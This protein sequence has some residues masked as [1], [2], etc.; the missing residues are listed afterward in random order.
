MK[1]FPDII[2]GSERWE[3]LRRERPTA[4]NFKK[5]ITAKKGEMSATAKPYAAHLA[6]Q[7]YFNS[8]PDADRR[9]AGNKNTDAGHEFEPEAREKFME[10]TGLTVVEVGFMSEDA[11]WF[12]G[13][14]DGLILKPGVDLERDAIRNEAGA[15]INGLELF[16]GGVELKSPMAETH[17]EWLLDGGLP[18]EHRAQVHASLFISGLPVWH[19][20]AWNKAMP[21]PVH[22]V[23]TPDAFTKSLAKAANDFRILYIETR[24]KLA[25]MMKTTPKTN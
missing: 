3:N 19:F 6:M 24:K 12:S 4:S 17:T 1:V 8:D 11:E 5:I 25:P 9:W 7:S 14:P 13:S 22:V 23:T 15:I 18:D 16:L 2:Q 21:S 10:Y 20:F